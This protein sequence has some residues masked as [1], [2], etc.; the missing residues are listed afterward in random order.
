MARFKCE[1]AESDVYAQIAARLDGDTEGK[2][3]V[4]MAGANVLIQHLR[5]FLTANTSDP[6]AAVRGTLANSLTAEPINASVF[7]QPK[8]KHHGKSSRKKKGDGY[9]RPRKGQGTSAKRQGHHGMTAGTSARDV[10]FMLE[11]G[12]ERT[13]ALHWMQQ[14]VEAHAE[15]VQDAMAEEFYKY[16]DE[17]GL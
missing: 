9:H 4:C 10:G 14:T 3:R 13:D 6:N 1:M 8:G 11:F 7:V 17:L 2:L 12:T 15:D 16:L 5:D